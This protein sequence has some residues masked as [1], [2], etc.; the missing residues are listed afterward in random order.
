MSSVLIYS[1]YCIQAIYS[2][3][4][5]LSTIIYAARERARTY[6]CMSAGELRTWEGAII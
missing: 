1:A 4:V 2:N 6:V 5:P 3:L